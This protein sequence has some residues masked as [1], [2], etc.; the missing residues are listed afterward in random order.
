MKKEQFIYELIDN[1]L[2]YVNLNN[3]VMENYTCKERTAKSLD[4]AIKELKLCLEFYDKLYKAVKSGSIDERAA[5][6]KLEFIVICL[7]N[8]VKNAMIKEI[9]KY[10][11]KYVASVDEFLEEN[12]LYDARGNERTISQRTM[13]QYMLALRQEEE[14]IMCGKN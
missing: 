6:V 11:A 9:K 2:Y 13:E 12:L 7:S 4:I 8:K 14:S 5:D 10:S 3:I 1:Y